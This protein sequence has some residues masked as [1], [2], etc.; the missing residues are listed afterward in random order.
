MLRIGE[1]KWN[2]I[3]ELVYQIN[4]ETSLFKLRKTFLVTVKSLINYDR[5]FFDL[6]YKKD[7]TAIFFDPV[8]EN[9]SEKYIDLY[10]NEYQFVDTMYWFFSQDQSDI[11]RESDFISKAMEASSVFYSEWLK[12]QDIHYSMGSKVMFNGTLYGSVNLWRSEAH[13]DFS[14]EEVQIMTIINKHLALRLYSQFPNGIKKNNE[15]E[16]TETLAHLYHLTPRELEIIWEIY[17]GHSTKEIGELLYIS[18]N[19]VK[20]HSHNIFQKMSVDS[21]TQLIKIVH[22]HLFE[23]EESLK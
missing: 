6:G 23:L 16:Y 14:D 5:G 9:M 11:Y 15:N 2:L 3:N 17:N 13:G 1:E 10:Y 4:A 8:S 20:K 12:P 18:D 22:D 7:T 21:R 19:T